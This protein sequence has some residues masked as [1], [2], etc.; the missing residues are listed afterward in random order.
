MKNINVI[1]I[2]LAKNNFQLHGADP[3]G[4]VLFRQSLP[5]KELLSFLANQPVSLI[6]V[7]GSCGAHYWA[8]QFQAQG[9]QV[10]MMNAKFVKPYVKSHQ[11]NDA[12]DAEAI[13][14]AASRENVRAIGVKSDEAL[15][16]QFSLRI[17][18]RHIKSRTAAINQARGFLQEFGVVIPKARSRFMTGV[19]ELLN[20]WPETLSPM[21]LSQIEA[22]FAEIKTLDK[23][24]LKADRELKVIVMRSERGR[25]FMKLR[26]V[27]LITAT[28][29]LVELSD[30]TVFENGRHFSAFLGLVPRQHSS[31]GKQRLGSISK[32]GDRYV[33]TL[34]VHGARSVLARAHHYDN[35]LSRWA[36]NLKANRGS[37][38]AAVAMANKTARQLWAVAMKTPLMSVD[39]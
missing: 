25:A 4:K 21:L 9:H 37:N 31:G 39:K 36:L 28:A 27:G 2:D 18:E 14:E 12:K 24:I 34:L 30:P 3:T 10:K 1:G 33:R 26:G 19:S 8:K 13:A 23:T 22:L 15:T 7:E 6:G 35:D 20:K 38:I 5:R 32:H 29:M 11:K 16:L 17:R